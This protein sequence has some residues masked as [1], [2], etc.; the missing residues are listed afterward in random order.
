MPPFRLILHV[1]RSDV[2]SLATPTHHNP[3]RT[4]SSQLSA[5]IH[6]ARTSRPGGLPKTSESNRAGS[7][8]FFNEDDLMP[9]K[10]RVP[11]H[12]SYHASKD[13]IMFMRSASG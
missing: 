10:N 2:V 11:F 4:V 7:E 6:E 8:S 5:P 13:G 3:M 9:D 1:A 12:V